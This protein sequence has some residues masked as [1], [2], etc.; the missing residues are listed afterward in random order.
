MH[1]DYG[2]IWDTNTKLKGDYIC[3]EAIVG[4]SDVRVEEPGGVDSCVCD[5]PCES[6]HVKPCEAN[7][8][9]SQNGDR[10]HGYA[11]AHRIRPWRIARSRFETLRTRCVRFLA[12]RFPRI[13]WS[14][15]ISR[16][17][18]QRTRVLQFLSG[19]I[20]CNW[21]SFSIKDWKNRICRF[22]IL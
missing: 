4:V 19:T 3:A 7:Y 11:Y 10:D 16:K 9:V 2:T 14:L 17:C 13:D 8:C 5:D 18:S 1:R 15:G 12:S 22:R 6:R 20:Y 21:T